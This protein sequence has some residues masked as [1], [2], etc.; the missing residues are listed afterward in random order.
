MKEG[1]DRDLDGR[2][3]GGKV[4]GAATTDAHDGL[5]LEPARPAA[6]VADDLVQKKPGVREP[7]G[8]VGAAEAVAF[9]FLVVEEPAHL[10]Q[11]TRIGQI[12]HLWH[13]QPPRAPNR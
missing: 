3:K 8:I 12:G 6:E 5:G 4:P 1:V 11:I 13:V 2:R 9:I 10:V 7:L